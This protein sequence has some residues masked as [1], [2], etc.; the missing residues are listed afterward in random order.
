MLGKL[1]HQLFKSLNSYTWYEYINFQNT[2][3]DESI[4]QGAIGF[5]YTKAVPGGRFNLSYEHR[6][7]SENRN[8]EPNLLRVFDE[9]LTLSDDNITLLRNQDI[10]PG[11]LLITD[12]S[13]IIIYQENIDYLVIYR[14]GL[15]EIQRLPGGQIENNQVVFADY[16]SERNTSYDFNTNADQFQAGIN[17]FERLMELYFRY[18]GQ[19]YSN[20]H[21][22]ESKI[23]KT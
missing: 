7:R 1:D 4:R 18:Y 20:I 2:A 3:Y 14:E 13:G 15:T 12:E 11:S 5:R 16:F 19:D 6:Q 17:L 8:S 21:M 22:T 23:L 9:E 10:D